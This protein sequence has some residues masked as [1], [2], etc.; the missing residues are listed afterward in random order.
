MTEKEYYQAIKVP[1]TWAINKIISP[2]RRNKKRVS[3]FGVK[4]IAF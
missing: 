1:G 4:L 3:I 2:K